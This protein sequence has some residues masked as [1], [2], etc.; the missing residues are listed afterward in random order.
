MWD[1]IREGS[2]L[3]ECIRILPEIKG[4]RWCIGGIFVATLQDKIPIKAY[5]VLRLCLPYNRGT[6]ISR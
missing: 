2:V 3:D 6:P 5:K 4:I 1:K